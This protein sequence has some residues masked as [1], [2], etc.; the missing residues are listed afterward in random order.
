ME[1]S[2]EELKGMGFRRAGTVY[3]DASAVV[4]VE[5]DWDHNGYAVYAMRVAGDIKKFGTT[6]RKNSSFKARMNSTFS[7]LRQT[8]RRG[9][10]FAGDPFKRF[11]PATI[12]AK[13][14]VELWLKPS[15]V[16]E[17]EVE[18]TRLNTAYR[19]Q[20]TKEGC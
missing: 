19:P 15:S 14:E 5:V 17:F 9:A 13:R 2:N 7:A 18:E 16:D 8:I 6:G 11:A 20:W 1:I 10:P 12:L 3:P 4:R